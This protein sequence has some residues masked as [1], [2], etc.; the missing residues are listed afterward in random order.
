MTN[1]GNKFDYHGIFKK[2]YAFVPQKGSYYVH[3]D[4]DTFFLFLLE[5]DF[6]IFHV[7]FFF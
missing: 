4:A 3:N 1:P 5:K 7:F 6:N 2:Y